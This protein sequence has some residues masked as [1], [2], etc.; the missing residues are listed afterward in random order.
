MEIQQGKRGGRVE[1]R[2]D[3]AYSY[4]DFLIEHLKKY[5]FCACIIIIVNIIEGFNYENGVFAIYFIWA[6]LTALW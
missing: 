4:I 6:D 2:Y 3:G 1:W 5:L